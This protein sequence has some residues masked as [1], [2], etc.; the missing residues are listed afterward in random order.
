VK[1]L[2]FIE[3]VAIFVG[4]AFFVYILIGG[5]L[6]IVIKLGYS[7]IYSRKVEMG[8]MSVKIYED[9]LK[10]IDRFFSVPLDI[11]L[12]FVYIVMHP[13]ILREIKLSKVL[14]KTFWKDLRGLWKGWKQR[15]EKK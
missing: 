4:V 13:W 3:S 12:V 1:F 8:K 7:A 11:M 2:K 10:R 6:N 9:K 15:N 5:F 14:S